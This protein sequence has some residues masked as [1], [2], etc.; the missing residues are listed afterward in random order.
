MD[1][2]SQRIHS[3]RQ[4]YQKAT[5][6]EDQAGD[7]P[8]LFFKKWFEEAQHSDI[9]EVNA[10]TVATATK[11]AIPDARIVLLKGI[12]KNGSFVFFT[13]Y[14]S[15]KGKELLENSKASLVF[16]WK[17][18]ERQVRIQGDVSK[19]MREEN[20]LYF[21]S[22]PLPSR[23]SAIVSP[24]SQRI[25]DRTQLE[26]ATKQQEA[27]DENNIICPDN[28]GGYQVMPYK[29]EFWQGRSNRLHDRIVFE[30]KQ[31]GWDKYRLAP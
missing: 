30:K 12:N 24:Q 29:I 17:E 13:N 20:I 4:D 27:L 31:N 3:I 6:N 23:I 26:E 21:D 9:T 7:D 10:M 28:W 2:F 14:D 8:V 1:Q 22:R 5:L 19:I 11:D 25:S 18:L 15:A 16:F